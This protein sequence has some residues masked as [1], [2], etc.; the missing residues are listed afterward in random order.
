MYIPMYRG[1][2][3]PTTTPMKEQ[4]HYM[5]T[6]QAARRKKKKNLPH[7]HPVGGWMA[8]KMLFVVST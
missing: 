5:T 3:L 6:Q 8:G 2:L 1:T 7:L 4:R